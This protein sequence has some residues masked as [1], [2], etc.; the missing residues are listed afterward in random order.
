MMESHRP[1]ANRAEAGRVL[2]R[3]LAHYT[4]KNALVLALPRGGVPVADEIARAI[5]GTLD[6]LMVRKLGVPWQRELGMGALVEGGAPIL[7]HALVDRVGVTPQEVA[8]VV[9]HERYELER[10]VHRYR[11]GHPLTDVRGRIVIVVDDGIATGGTMQV[12]LHSVRVRGAARVVLAVPVASADSLARLRAH[13]DEVVCVLQPTR[14]HS[15]GE[16]YEDFDQVSDDEV[17]AVLLRA[18]QLAA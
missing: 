18:R 17:D 11:D 16:W 9:A 6:V 1:F 4:D 10:R 5:G 14:L 3:L 8:E 13:A 2:G 15:V 12:A 7:D